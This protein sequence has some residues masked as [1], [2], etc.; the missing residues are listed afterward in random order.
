MLSKAGISCNGSDILLNFCKSCETSLSNEDS[1]SPPKF[2]IANGLWIGSLPMRF[3]D[4][5]R[6]ENS[7]MNL[8]QSN[9]AIF[10]IVGGHNRKLT[11]HIYSFRAIPSVPASIFS[12]RYFKFRRIES[13][14]SWIAYHRAKHDFKKEIRRAARASS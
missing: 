6:I 1:N 4:T 7:M 10:T 14:N 13:W 12:S 9:A 11:S 8:A 2:A 5:S 3:H